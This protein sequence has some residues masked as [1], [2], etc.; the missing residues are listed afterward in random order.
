MRPQMLNSLCSQMVI[1]PYLF[2][3]QLVTSLKR[4]RNDLLSLFREGSWTFFDKTAP[5]QFL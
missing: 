3:S 1:S 2:L 5:D 4:F